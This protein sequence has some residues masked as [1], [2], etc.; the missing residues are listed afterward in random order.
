MGAWGTDLWED[1]LSC[2]IQDEWNELLD[3]G[4][5]P[6]KATKVILKSW[7]EEFSEYDDE[8]DRLADESIL[9]IALAALQMRHRALNH[10][11]KKMAIKLI[12]KGADLSLWEEGDEEDYQDRK[13]VLEEFKRKLISTKAR[14]F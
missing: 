12:D 1:D 8:E 2:D 9:F 6:R 5:S 4:I 10:Y 3:E 13:K 7:M 14:L 11:V